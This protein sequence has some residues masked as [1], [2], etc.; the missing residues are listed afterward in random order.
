MCG[1]VG[2]TTPTLC[3]GLQA[4][5]HPRGRVSAS[6]SP[7]QSRCGGRHTDAPLVDTLPSGVVIAATPSVSTTCGG[8]G[9]PVAVAGAV[10]GNLAGGTL[11]PA[12]GSCTVTV[13]VTAA[14]AV[15]TLNVLPAGALV[16]PPGNNAAAAVAILNVGRLGATSIPTLSE[17]AMI[18]LAA[19]LVLFGVQEFVG[20]RL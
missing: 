3:E 14:V 9:A 13:D 17:W 6:P 15:R 18:M 4:V 1:L 8:V 5:Q 19:L 12:T 2:G 16:P 10:D 11:D 7:E 20:T